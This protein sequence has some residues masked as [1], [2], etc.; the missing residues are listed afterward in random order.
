MRGEL[1]SVF[2]TNAV[3]SAMLLPSSVPRRA[4]DCAL[5]Q[6]KLLI[7]AATLRELD[8]VIRRPR[9]DRYL[10]EEDRLE[11]LTMLVREAEFVHVTVVVT[12]CRDARDNK[13]LE[14]AVSGRATHI[15][16]GDSDLLL[17]NPFRGIAVVSPSAM[18][19]LTSGVTSRTPTSPPPRRRS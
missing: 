18:A 3:V 10:S 5:E 6:G 16:T 15:V 11:F 1:R 7:S 13:F 14:L 4:F 2:D 9:F 19:A 8:A 12:E 17:V